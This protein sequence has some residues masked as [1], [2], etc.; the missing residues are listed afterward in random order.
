MARFCANCG[1]EVDDSAVFCPT[2]GQPVD[3]A[4]ETEMPPAPA[5]PKPADD[6]EPEDEEPE[7]EGSVEQPTRV[8][9]RPVPPPA[10]A[11]P[12]DRSPRPAAPRREGPT[13]DLPLTMPVTLSAW[14]IGVGSFV[15]ALG[16]IVSLFGG[17]LN[18]IEILLVLALLGV[19]AT[20]FLSASLPAIP[21][22]RLVTLIVVL[23]AFGIAL[24]RLAFGAAGIGELL[25]FLG[26][27]AAAI[28]A[29][30]LELG[31]D[32]PLGGAAG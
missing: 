7:D 3:Q 17:F 30:I 6:Q 23:I 18:V 31:R 4:A 21:H 8:E 32:Q 10:V 25:L 20:V 27:A 26:T 14:L 16:V 15:A 1:T 28:G 9:E 22:L 29:I 5:W 2:C 24:D 11:S 12:P 19:A 13:L